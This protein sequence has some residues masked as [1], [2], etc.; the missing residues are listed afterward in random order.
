MACAAYLLV[1]RLAF[2]AL[3]VKWCLPKLASH[4]RLDFGYN[5]QDHEGE[6]K[7]PRRSFY[8]YYLCFPHPR[9]IFVAPPS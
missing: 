7:T 2:I 5:L 9:G 1:P 3:K 8:A 4:A 6:M